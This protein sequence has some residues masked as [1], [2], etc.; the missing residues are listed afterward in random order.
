MTAKDLINKAG[1][2]DTAGFEA[3]SSSP[4]KTRTLEEELEVFAH[5]FPL[6]AAEFKLLRDKFQ[7]FRARFN[8]A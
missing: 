1:L 3:D 2:N 6:V 5:D 8:L 7:A 4:V